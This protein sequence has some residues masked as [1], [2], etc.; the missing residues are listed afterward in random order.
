MKKTLNQVG[1]LLVVVLVA[2]GVSAVPAAAQP[3]WFCPAGERVCLFDGSFGEPPSYD[4]SR[5]PGCMNLNAAWNDIANSVTNN[6]SL[7]VHLNQDVNCSG[8]GLWIDAHSS[9]ALIP[10]VWLSSLYFEGA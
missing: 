7:R 8:G 5:L 9:K 6:S 3:H 1:A 10:A 2:L 4:Y